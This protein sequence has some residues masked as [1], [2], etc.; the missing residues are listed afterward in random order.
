MKDYTQ[1][2][3]SA[4]NPIRASDKVQSILDYVQTVFKFDK[5]KLQEIVKLVLQF[6]V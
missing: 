4:I 1:V 2:V 6:K 5:E 3:Y